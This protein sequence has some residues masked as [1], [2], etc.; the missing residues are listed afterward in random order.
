[1]DKFTLSVN[2]MSAEIRGKQTSTLELFETMAN[3]GE[4]QHRT[5]FIAKAQ[6]Y[7]SFHCDYF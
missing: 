2:K 3:L 6:K 4:N 7:V 1:M 5:L